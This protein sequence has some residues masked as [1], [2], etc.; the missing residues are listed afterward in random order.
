MSMCDRPTA[1]GAP[2]PD[3]HEGDSIHDEAGAAFLGYWVQKL[4]LR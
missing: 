1:H 3:R 2:V 4:G